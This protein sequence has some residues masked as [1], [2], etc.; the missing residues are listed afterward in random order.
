MSE[1]I[2]LVIAD[3]HP[4]LREGL[5]QI[6]E[7]E[8]DL[9]VIAQA[10]NGEAALEHILAMRPDIAVLDVDMPRLN[11]FG[12]LRALQEKKIEV[13]V[14]MLTVHREEEFFNEAL[15]LGA[16]GY[17]LKDSAIDDIVS[18]IRAVAGGD[19]FVSPAMTKYLFQSRN[20]DPR[21]RGGLAT[22]T[23]SERQLLKLIADYRTNNQ[24]AEELHISPHTVKTHRKNICVKLNLEGNHALM[25]FALDHK[26]TL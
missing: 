9:R 22:L 14:I 6:I 1:L 26:A 12:V 3:D 4:I 8:A 5:R 2:R 7:K 17:V 16:R 25:K 19:N 13:G 10:D 24:I 23:P 21:S 20:Q 11:G 18:C 15:R